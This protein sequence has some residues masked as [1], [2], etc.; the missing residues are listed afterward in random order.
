MLIPEESGLDVI[1]KDDPT[2]LALAFDALD[3][4]V[5]KITQFPIC[6]IYERSKNK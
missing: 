5:G 6:Q 1:H 2:K 3:E 4:S